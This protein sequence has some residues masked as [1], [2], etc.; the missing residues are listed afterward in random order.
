MEGRQ[1]E[2]GMEDEKKSRGEEWQKRSKE[3]E[4]NEKYDGLRGKNK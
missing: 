4:K 1:R 3:M 2:G